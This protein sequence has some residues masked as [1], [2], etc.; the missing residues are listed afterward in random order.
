MTAQFDSTLLSL[1]APIM[2]N[3]ATDGLT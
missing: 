1:C 2:K 3:H